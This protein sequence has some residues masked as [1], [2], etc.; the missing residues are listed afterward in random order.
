MFSFLS[1]LFQPKKIPGTTPIIVFQSGKVGSM[2]MQASLTKKYKEIGV[3]IPI[4]HAHFL[5]DIDERIEFLSRVR[6]NPEAAIKKLL[7]SKELRNQIASHPEAPWNII[8]LTRDPVALL[9]SALFQV[10]DEFAP[11]WKQQLKSDE[12]YLEDLRKTLLENAEFEPGR[13]DYWFDT[14]I[15]PVCGFDALVAPFAKENGYQIYKP[16]SQI[17]LIIIRL[18]DL[19]RVAGRALQEFLGLDNFSI[20]NTNISEQKPYHKLYEEFKKMPLSS[21]YLNAAYATR[22]ARCFYSK[23]EIESFRKRWERGE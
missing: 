9:V 13:L 3:P 23:E 17:S 8:S 4:Y 12:A 1:G 20:V 10:I 21:S 14:Q 18:E 19:N 11:N 2:T 15:N 6:L 5:E 16:N 7:A 22:Y